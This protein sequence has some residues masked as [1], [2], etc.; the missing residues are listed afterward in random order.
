[1]RDQLDEIELITTWFYNIIG[2]ISCDLFTL[3]LGLFVVI[4]GFQILNAVQRKTM[5][6]YHQ[7][8]YFN[9]V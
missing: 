6:D 4:T 9:Y 2:A 5:V 1:M 7:L 3:Y 8:H